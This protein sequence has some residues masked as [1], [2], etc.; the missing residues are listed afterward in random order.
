MARRNNMLASQPGKALYI[1]HSTFTG[2][3]GVLAVSLLYVPRSLRPIRTW[4]YKTALITYA[5]RLWIHYAGQVED[6]VT[7][8]LHPGKEGERWVTLQP[9][10]KDKYTG[11]MNDSQISPSLIGGAWYPTPFS[12]TVVFEIS[13][14]FALLRLHS[15]K[16]RSEIR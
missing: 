13:Y 15:R 12:N 8:S 9:R 10:E 7:L 6:S 16:D 3:V 1:L 14:T 5:Y 4:S 2:L 11:P